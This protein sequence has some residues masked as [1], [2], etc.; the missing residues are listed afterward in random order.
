M[1]ITKNKLKQLIKEEME[2]TLNEAGGDPRANPTYNLAVKKIM[3][4]L[5][6]ALQWPNVRFAGIASNPEG[7]A[8][9]FIVR[10][11]IIGRDPRG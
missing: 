1:K 4:Y 10:F 5:D 6:D 8:D 7:S 2:N 11:E 9:D 3:M